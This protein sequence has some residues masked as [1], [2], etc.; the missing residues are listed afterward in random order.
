MLIPY[1]NNE[2]NEARGRKQRNEAAKRLEDAMTRLKCNLELGFFP[3]YYD[4]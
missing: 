3:F 1:L 4:L 2:E